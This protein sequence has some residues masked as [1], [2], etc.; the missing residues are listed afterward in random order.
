MPHVESITPILYLVSFAV[1]DEKSQLTR[2][3]SV[4]PT[5]KAVGRRI[6]AGRI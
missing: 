6:V 2:L 1:L 5:N 3:A 4:R